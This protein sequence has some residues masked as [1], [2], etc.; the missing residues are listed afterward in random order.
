MQCIQKLDSADDSHLL[1]LFKVEIDSVDKMF[2]IYLDVHK[3]VKYSDACPEKICDVIS[4]KIYKFTSI[5]FLKNNTS[6]ITRKKR[7]TSYLIT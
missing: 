4:G 6:M 1:I 2:W 7:Q 3:H 5:L